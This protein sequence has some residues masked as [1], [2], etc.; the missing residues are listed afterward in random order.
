MLPEI[1]LSILYEVKKTHWCDNVRA[2]VEAI[3]TET[4]RK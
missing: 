1:R 4:T 2:T 3:E